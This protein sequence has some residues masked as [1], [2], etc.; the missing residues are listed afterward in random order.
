MDF[1]VGVADYRLLIFL[2]G[3]SLHL[4]M[5]FMI[6]WD[7]PFKWRGPTWFNWTSTTRTNSHRAAPMCRILV[8]SAAIRWCKVFL[9]SLWRSLSIFGGSLS[10]LAVA[11][12]LPNINSFWKTNWL[13]HS[14]GRALHLWRLV[15]GKSSG[16]LQVVLAAR[17][18]LG[19]AVSVLQLSSAPP[20]VRNSSGWRGSLFW[21]LSWR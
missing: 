4:F 20:C 18:D 6:I 17:T 5:H 13:V 8:S 10:L 3:T 16:I 2:T 14:R 19:F 9:N 11:W 15:L 12:I 1:S 7:W 21:S